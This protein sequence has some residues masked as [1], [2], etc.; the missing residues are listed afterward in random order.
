MMVVFCFIIG[1]GEDTHIVPVNVFMM[2]SSGKQ[3]QYKCSMTGK[4]PETLQSQGSSCLM[5]VI[6]IQFHVY[7]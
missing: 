1:E 2:P 4:N 5:T 7:P 3:V 6:L